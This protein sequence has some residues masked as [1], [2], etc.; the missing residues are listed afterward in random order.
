MRTRFGSY[1]FL[2]MPFGLTNAPATFMMMMNTVFHDMLD[3]GV[4]VFLDDILSYAKTA[5]EHEKILREVLKRLRANHLFA[6]PSKCEFGVQ[7]VEFLGHTITPEG[8]KPSK[9]KLEAIKNWESPRTLTATRSFVGFVSFYRRYIQG[10][11]NVVSPLYALTKKGQ[12]FEWTMECE[13]A[14]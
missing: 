3:R 9:D 14:F 6:K 13:K 11:A 4:V 2:V 7:E 10:F 8:M 1:E 5:V 12:V